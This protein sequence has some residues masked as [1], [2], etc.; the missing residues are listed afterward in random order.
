[1]NFWVNDTFDIFFDPEATS[2]KDS[3]FVLKVVK[4]SLT[5][6]KNNKEYKVE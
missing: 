4:K 3:R 5:S 2:M 1:L 6:I